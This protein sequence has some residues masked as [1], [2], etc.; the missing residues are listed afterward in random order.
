MFGVAEL[1]VHGSEMEGFSFG[2][3]TTLRVGLET[4]L[5][6]YSKNSGVSRAE[7][8]QRSE[9]E[10]REEN[11]RFEQFSFNLRMRFIDSEVLRRKLDCGGGTIPIVATLLIGTL[12]GAPLLLTLGA[13]GLVGWFS[14][15]KVVSI[16]VREISSFFS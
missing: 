9:M 14:A 13:A 5:D 8:Q 16:V 6:V 15:K 2:K 4:Y 11:A 3:K 10:Q 12:S 1:L 7:L